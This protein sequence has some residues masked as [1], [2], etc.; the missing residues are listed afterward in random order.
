M[1]PPCCPLAA[2]AA[3]RRADLVLAAV[4]AECCVSAQFDFYAGIKVAANRRMYWAMIEFV[5][6]FIMFFINFLS[7]WALFV[8]AGVDVAATAIC[9]YVTRTYELGIL[10]LK[11]GCNPVPEVR[12]SR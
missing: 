6:F 12:A 8:T 4:L 11:N 10:Q 9:A 3:H 7:P 5:M 1:P 2:D